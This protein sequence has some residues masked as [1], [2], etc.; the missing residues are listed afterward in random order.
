[1]GLALALSRA[2]YAVTVVG[3]RK[4]RL[5]PPLKLTVVA[6]D[7]TPTWISQV[8]VVVLA[9]GDDAI[10]PLAEQLARAGTV[11]P[12]HVV[13]HLS[14]VQGQ[15]ALGPLVSTRAAL[16]SLHPPPD[17]QRSGAGARAPAGG[18]GGGGGDAAGR[19]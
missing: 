17:D 10:R 2:R 11:T 14:G 5:P 9:V 16:G 3:R 13:L 1:M 18:V 4:Q 8:G 6:D 7:V 12:D 15:E 19:G